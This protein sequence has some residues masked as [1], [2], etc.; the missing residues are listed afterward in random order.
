M[1]HTY[2][3]DVPG[4]LV[5]GTYT[6]TEPD[7][8]DPGWQDLKIEHTGL[9]P[10]TIIH[11]ADPEYS[12]TWTGTF[13]YNGET[14]HIKVWWFQ[15]KVVNINVWRDTDADAPTGGPNSGSGAL[16][17]HYTASVLVTYNRINNGLN[18][19]ASFDYSDNVYVAADG[20]ELSSSAYDV[21]II[22]VDD[23]DNGDGTTTYVVE[24]EIDFDALPGVTEL[25]IATYCK[26]F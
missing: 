3:E 14:Y 4:G 6:Y 20:A 11:F 15:K 7:G 25:I 19:D 18:I 10:T 21:T 9:T 26:D 1:S 17:T 12:G 16:G 13:T 24:Y 23:T 5:K 8:E 22:D 2:Q